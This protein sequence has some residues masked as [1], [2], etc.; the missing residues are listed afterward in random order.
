[1]KYYLIT[2]LLAL[3]LLSCGKKEHADLFD[4][5]KPVNLSYILQAYEWQQDYEED[6]KDSILTEK[7]AP[8]L[9][10]I[11][12]TVLLILLKEWP[13]IDSSITL[14]PVKRCSLK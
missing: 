14:M 5:S 9:P 3:S 2:L 12:L 10:S 13:W 6:D 11:H 8:G 7:I 4:Y 1:M